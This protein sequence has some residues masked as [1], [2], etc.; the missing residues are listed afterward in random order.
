MKPV[1]KL[2][3]GTVQFG[4]NY[5]INNQSGRPEF[6]EVCHI[7]DTAYQAGICLLD[8][9]E[10]YGNAQQVIGA[11]HAKA[12]HRFNVITKFDHRMPLGEGG[13]GQ[14]IQQ[15]LD[16]LQ[17][18][19]LYAYMFHSY[20][21]YEAYFKPFQHELEALISEGKIGKIGVSVYTNTE[22]TAVIEQG[23]VSLV[24]IP[25]NLLENTLQRGQ[26]IDRAKQKG[27]EVHTRSVF[28]QGLFFMDLER[29]PLQ[30]KPL[31]PYLNQLNEIAQA[32]NLSMQALALNYAIYNEGIDC[33][34]IGT[35]R[36]EQLL[37][38]LRSI[39]ATSLGAWMKKV[40]QIE[41][42]EVELLNPVNWKA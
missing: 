2:I 34:L 18:A 39:Q 14:R 27:I 25:F 10:A 30:L 11:Y 20:K 37:E 22:L 35:E 7:L 17:V 5:G 26:L 12:I 40:D 15:D 9:A 31:V 23:L 41:V 4:L 6:E 38:N 24:Q 8:T 3:L 13:I 36:K 21:D 28:L 16:E 1:D 42:N 19:S 29:I 33:V 32:E